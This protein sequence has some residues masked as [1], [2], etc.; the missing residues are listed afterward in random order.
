M[1]LEPW[2][3]LF[4]LLV[5][6]AVRF[7]RSCRNHLLEGLVLQ[8]Q[9]AALARRHSRPPPFGVGPAFLGCVAAILVRMEK[10]ACNRAT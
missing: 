10:D 3:R 2:L 1:T 5:T 8:Q 9:L 7:L 4:T 6:L